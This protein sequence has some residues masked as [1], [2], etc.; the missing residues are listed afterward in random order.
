MNELKQSSGNERCKYPQINLSLDLHHLFPMLATAILIMPKVVA[1]LL[2]AGLG[3]FFSTA[4]GTVLTVVGRNLL[5][6]VMS[7]PFINFL[8][9]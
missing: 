3:F 2:G 6:L 4:T 9:P 8:A 1:L 7:S 5:K